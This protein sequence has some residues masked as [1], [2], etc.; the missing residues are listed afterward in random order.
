MVI[1]GM[2]EK[3][4]SKEE[5]KKVDWGG[6]LL[7]K[8]GLYI[9]FRWHL[10][11]ILKEMRKNEPCKYLGEKILNKQSFAC[12]PLYDLVF[13]VQKHL[14]TK[15]IYLNQFSERTTLSEAELLKGIRMQTKQR[16]PFS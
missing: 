7:V 1:S 8:E 13:Y 9:T 3:K 5:N 12:D 6:L 10:S 2:G 14:W 11:R 15:K 16:N 4:K